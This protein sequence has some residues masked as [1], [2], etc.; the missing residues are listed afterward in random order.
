MRRILH[1]SDIHFGPY[2]LPEVAAGVTALVKRRRPDLVIIS[3]DLTQRAKSE[4]FKDAR[5]WVD[6]LPVPTLA[7]PGNHD[8]PMYRVWER[9]LSPFDA[10]RRHF[11]EEMEPIFEDDEL[12]VIGVNTAF[13]WT[14]KDGRF[15]VTGL[16][17]LARLL[18]NAPEDKARIVVAHH[19]VVPP[20]RFDTQRVAERAREAV[21][22]MS[23]HGVELVLSGHLHQ[24]Y[25][26]TSEEY[27]PSG[28]RPVFLVHTGTTTSRRGRSWERQRN[29]C[30][31]LR[32]DDEKISVHHLLWDE[33]E[34]AFL[35]WSR[36]LF[37][38]RSTS[39]FSL[40][41]ALDD[42]IR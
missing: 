36:H 23:R 7:V 14:V 18:E 28:R 20:P 27:Y 32:I 39:L 10:Y 38:R 2:F 3:G 37:P 41:D 35:E 17:R 13:N 21:E 26:A 19:H 6:A 16:R 24:T 40:Q 31:W 1:V 29:S 34:S 30:N 42:A 25:I 15:T 5:A 4:Q 33:G 8:V 9:V 22:L 12:Y 11:A